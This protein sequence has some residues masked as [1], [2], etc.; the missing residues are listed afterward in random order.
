MWFISTMHYL[1]KFEKFKIAITL[2]LIVTA[3]TTLNSCGQTDYCLMFGLVIYI[4]I[5]YIT[6][7]GNIRVEIMYNSLYS[8]LKTRIMEMKWKDTF[9]KPYFIKLFYINIIEN[10]IL[11]YNIYCTGANE[12][13][14]L[15]S[16]SIYQERST[17]A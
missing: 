17:K 3:C 16:E 13:N 14:L 8:V 11:K 7:H 1:I 9:W 10:N 6:W 5:M 2:F 4:F 15:H 12:T